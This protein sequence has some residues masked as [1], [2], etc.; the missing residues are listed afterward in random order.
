MQSLA[1]TR[2]L[3]SCAF[4]VV[5]LA[6]FSSPG[7]AQTKY[8]LKK[9]TNPTES[10]NK[11]AF[12]F[13]KKGV[14]SAAESRWSDAL[15]S[16][17]ESYRKSGQWAPLYNVATT[18]R[19]LGRHREARDAFSQFLKMHEDD[20]P[21]DQL[22]QAKRMKDEAAL[23]VAL[24]AIEDL[25]TSERMVLRMDGSK[26]SI[27]NDRPLLLETDPGRHVLRVELPK[28]EPFLWEGALGDGDRRTIR[29]Q[30]TEK[31]EPSRSVAKSPLFWIL[32]A[33]V[34]GGIAVGL[35][36][37]L[38]KDGVQPMSDLVVEL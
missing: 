10:A 7:L 14:A 31:K 24:L 32:T 4:A 17:E 3:C 34:A 6:M 28:F 37:I 22:E 8:S 36:F 25:P 12:E 19:S 38:K 35:F 33:V 1:K 18:L 13:Y 9:P 5:A 29:I 20:A 30:L 26:L 23:R 16:F 27:G 2:L 21:A 11:E 15:A